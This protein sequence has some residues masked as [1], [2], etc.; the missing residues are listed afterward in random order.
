MAAN[1]IFSAE[2]HAS[3]VSGKW[4]ALTRTLIRSILHGEADVSKR[5]LPAICEALSDVLVLSGVM[6]TAEEIQ[7]ELDG[8]FKERLW[9]ILALA[10]RL[11]EATGEEIVSC[12]IKAASYT[13]GASFDPDLM[14]D[15][16]G[17]SVPGQLLEGDIVFCTTDL[18]LQKEICEGVEGNTFR[19]KVT[20][21]K[22]KVAL[23]SL[24]DAM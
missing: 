19:Q 4:R 16:C 15:S 1:N 13:G 22:P 17:R 11:N 9:I 20:L 12:D 10:L 2:I 5:L 23:E 14:G 24:L 21:L 8:K 6:S 7:E 18:G 3:E